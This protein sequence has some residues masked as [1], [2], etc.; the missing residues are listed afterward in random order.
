MKKKNEKKKWIISYKLHYTLVNS[1]KPCYT[2]LYYTILCCIVLRCMCNNF[3]YTAIKTIVRCHIL[4]FE[5]NK[6][7]RVLFSI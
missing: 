7:T 5:S 3:I 2:I 6:K 1:T 4:K